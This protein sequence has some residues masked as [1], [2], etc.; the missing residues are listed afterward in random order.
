MMSDWTARNPYP[1][2]D[3]TETCDFCGCKFR[4]QVSK[5]D[6]HNESEEY[7]CPDCRKEFRVRA[8]M[9]PQVTKINDRTDGRTIRYN[10]HHKVQ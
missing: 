8:S 2:G 9:T 7:Y 5:Q 10:E 1:A 3:Y 4:V 6:G